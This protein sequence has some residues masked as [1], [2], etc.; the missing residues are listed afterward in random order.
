M[1]I[2][3]FLGLLILI[4][5]TGC[6]MH[7]Q[8][9]KLTEDINLPPPPIPNQPIK[10]QTEQELIQKHNQ[11][12]KLQYF[13]EYKNITLNNLIITY[14]TPIHIRDGLEHGLDFFI[15]LNNPTNNVKRIQ[16]PQLN[17]LKKQLPKTVIH[18]YQF[19]GETIT[20]Q[21]KEEKILH[22]FHSAEFLGNH[23]LTFIFKDKT[24][25]AK[26][27]IE[28]AAK[29]SN[30]L[31]LT[32]SIQGQVTD[33]KGYPISNVEVTMHAYS[34]RLQHTAF[35]NSKGNYKIALEAVKDLELNFKGRQHIFKSFAYSLTA[36]HKGYEYYFKHGISPKRKEKIHQDIKLKPITQPKY[37]L[38]FE[39]QVKEPYG[40]FWADKLGENVVAIQAKHPEGFKKPTNI[41]SF[42]MKGNVKWTFPTKDECWGFDV[43]VKDTVAVGCGEGSIHVIDKYGKE[44]WSH[45]A[46]YMV[47]TVKFSNDGKYLIAGP[48]NTRADIA[49][50]DAS[51]G[52]AIWRNA[53]YQNWLRNA[54]FSDDDS[55]IVAGIS[56][57]LVAF[58]IKGKKLWEH[59]TGQFPM[60]LAMDQE[61]NTFAV[62]KSR[63]LFS[64]DKNGKLRFK[65]RIPDH[66]VTAGAMSKKSTFAMGTVGGWVYLFD[67]NGIMWRHNTKGVISIG[68]NAIDI[69]PD[70]KYI[71][72]GTAAAMRPGEEGKGS[73]II[74]FDEKGSILWR[75][76]SKDNPNSNRMIMGTMHVSISDDGSTI[77]AS[78]GDN[79]LRVF[80]KV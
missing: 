21:P 6:D 8:T 72:V 57:N 40:F 70:G 10:I 45:K 46:D 76:K 4:V 53:L 30:Y 55:M 50:F 68:H 75:N 60:F 43:S 31:P 48:T 17:D 36:S 26:I 62:G 11:D 69:T 63:T 20:L 42:D 74:V 27:N 39:K 51:T 5:I 56:K 23:T 79:Y 77:I 25:K 19:H 73:E 9:P 7:D 12:Q 37:K 49:M 15:K 78:Y 3:W 64:F 80:Q 34:G 2:R 33:I 32:S 24:S 38:L 59:N 35:T 18:L 52:K 61:K 41:Y 65:T 58:D 13:S 44:L 1:E 22:Y 47:R 28:F 16:L 29:K 67:K 71:V 66:T 14:S 54:A